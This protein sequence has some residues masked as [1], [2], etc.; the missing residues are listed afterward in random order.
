MKAYFL[1]FNE[2]FSENPLNERLKLHASD[3]YSTGKEI[4]YHDF[5]T[6][7]S[8]LMIINFDYLP[9]SRD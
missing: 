7:E 1:N 9:P 6:N 2:F 5:R 8:Y 3:E 4:S